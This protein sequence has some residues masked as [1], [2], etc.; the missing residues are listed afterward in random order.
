M[1]RQEIKSIKESIPYFLALFLLLILVLYSYATPVDTFNSTTLPSRVVYDQHVGNV[2]LYQYR[3]AAATATW[4]SDI[5][6]LNGAKKCSVT[7]FKATGLTTADWTGTLGT[8][9][10]Y[11]YA[12][13][14]A[15]VDFPNAAVAGVVPGATAAMIKVPMKYGEKAPAINT[16][17]VRGTT[18][19]DVYGRH[20]YDLEE[21]GG[22]THIQLWGTT[23]NVDN[24]VI[25]GLE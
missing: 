15:S 21:L 5:I 2:R 19:I 4:W 22:L 7:I 3:I 14:G 25:I 11:L 18:T 6:P 8:G 9:D 16:G 24:S 10:F 1:S 12:K 13:A 17:F 20:F 23:N